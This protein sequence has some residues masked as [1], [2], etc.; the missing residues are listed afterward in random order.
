LYLKYDKGKSLG[1]GKGE[2]T[3]GGESIYDTHTH[4]H[5]PLPTCI[6][7]PTKYCLRKWGREVRGI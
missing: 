7:K 6:K 1:R 4:A 2:G 5:T 3:V